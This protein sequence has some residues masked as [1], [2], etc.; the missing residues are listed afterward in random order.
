VR[1]LA[2]QLGDAK[3]ENRADAQLGIAA[4]YDGDTEAAG[5]KVATAV[6]TARQLTISAP[7]F[8]TCQQWDWA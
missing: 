7:R 6:Q 5:L 3:W 1:Q 2:Q 4:F 8:G